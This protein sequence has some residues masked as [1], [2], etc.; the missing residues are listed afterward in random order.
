MTWNRRIAIRIGGWIALLPLLFLNAI[1]LIKY[2]SW[3]AVASEY[4]GQQALVTHATRL[5]NLWLCVLATAE[6]TATII[7]FLLLPARMRLLRFLVPVLAIPLVTGAIA[8]AL[9]MLT[10]GPH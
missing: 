1:S 6:I 7:L 5:G 3:S 9:I 2:A 8:W 10:R 4:A